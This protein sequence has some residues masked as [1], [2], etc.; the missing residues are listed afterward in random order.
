MDEAE[1][2]AFDKEFP[3]KEKLKLPGQLFSNHRP[4][5]DTRMQKSALRKQ[6]GAFFLMP[7]ALPF[8]MTVPVGL[9][10]GEVYEIWNFSGLDGGHAMGAAADFICTF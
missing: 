4:D 3:P 7:F 8:I 2:E 10:F 5:A 1:A 9:V 6:R